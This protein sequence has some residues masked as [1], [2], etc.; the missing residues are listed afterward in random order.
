M[1]GPSRTHAETSKRDARGLQIINPLRSVATLSYCASWAV[2]GALSA[3]S[4]PEATTAAP[5]MSVRLFLFLSFR[6]RTLLV[7][8][9]TAGEAYKL[10]ILFPEKIKVVA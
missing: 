6:S 10:S 3:P 4:S 8:N 9:A 1:L 5:R 7:R 2:E